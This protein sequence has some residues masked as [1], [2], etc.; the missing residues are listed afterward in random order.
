MPNIEYM[1]PWF[2]S[3]ALIRSMSHATWQTLSPHAQRISRFIVR[4]R[5]E[6]VIGEG[7]N[8]PRRAERE[9]IYAEQL[10]ELPA[11]E[12]EAYERRA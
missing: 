11:D 6:P 12:A 10:A 4:E 3:E 8:H 1:A 7:I 5:G 9:R 2:R